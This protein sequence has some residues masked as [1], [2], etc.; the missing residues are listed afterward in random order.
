MINQLIALVFCAA[1]GALGGL[2][3]YVFLDELATDRDIYSLVLSG[4]V[5]FIGLLSILQ[6]LRLLLSRK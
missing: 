6:A 3:L 5:S 4:I 2:G 1:V